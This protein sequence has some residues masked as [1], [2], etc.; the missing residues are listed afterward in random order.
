MRSP[1]L[2]PTRARRLNS[3]P[4]SLHDFC[5]YQL[6]SLWALAEIGK[7]LGAVSGE[8]V[9]MRDAPPDSS[10][11]DKIQSPKADDDW[12]PEM[13]ASLGHN[14]LDDGQGVGGIQGIYHFVFGIMLPQWP[15]GLDNAKFRR[16]GQWRC[17]YRRISSM[18]SAAKRSMANALELTQETKAAQ[19]GHR[20]ADQSPG[21]SM[22]AVG[23]F[24]VATMTVAHSWRRCKQ[25]SQTIWGIHPHSLK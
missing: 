12:F 19:H 17:H 22:K 3:S 5:Q 21:T 9:G 25:A 15:E 1:K 13:R 2:R 16:W 8:L 14:G 11:G 18:D 4:A 24:I 20:R 10:R 7:A 23:R 6:C